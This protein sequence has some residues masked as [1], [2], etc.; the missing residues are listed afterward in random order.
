MEGMPVS[1]NPRTATQQPGVQTAAGS[2]SQQPPQQPVLADRSHDSVTKTV[3][4]KLTSA[5]LKRRN[6]N[7]KVQWDRAV[8]DNEKTPKVP[9]VRPPTPPPFK[10]RKAFATWLH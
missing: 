2:H 3:R 9:S 7:K 1:P 8:I 10:K 4:A 6:S 5:F